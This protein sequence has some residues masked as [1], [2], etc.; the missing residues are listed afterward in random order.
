MDLA[1]RK[2]FLKGDGKPLVEFRAGIS[3]LFNVT[4]F[5][6][7]AAILPNVLGT[8]ATKNHLQPG[9]PYT[10]AAGGTFGILNRTF[11]RQPDLGQADKSSSA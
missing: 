4:N 6:R 2:K 7:P 9:E 3:N 11:K 5:D 8:D 10:S 1:I